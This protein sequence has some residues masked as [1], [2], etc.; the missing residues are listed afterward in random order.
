MLS[1]KRLLIKLNL[2]WELLFIKRPHEESKNASYKPKSD[3]VFETYN[4]QGINI[5]KPERISRGQLE[6]KTQIK[7]WP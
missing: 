6:N 3:T 4:K 5:Q 1:K 7:K 2:N